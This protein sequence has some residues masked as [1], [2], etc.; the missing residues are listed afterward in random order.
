MPLSCLPP[1]SSSPMRGCNGVKRGKARLRERA[2]GKPGNRQETLGAPS[3]CTEASATPARRRGSTSPDCSGQ[4]A[5]L[6]PVNRQGEALLTRAT[7]I[8][9]GGFLL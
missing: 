4:R 3:A 8:K 6:H 5:F 7:A 1:R 9:R 2:H